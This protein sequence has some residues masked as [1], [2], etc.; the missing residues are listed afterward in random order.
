MYPSE[1]RRYIILGAV[2]GA[3]FLFFII[4]MMITQ[5]RDGED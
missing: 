4:V 2:I 5:L 1:K 3:V